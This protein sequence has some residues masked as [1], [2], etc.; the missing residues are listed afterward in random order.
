MEMLNP[1]ERVLRAAAALRYAGVRAQADGA[2]PINPDFEVLLAWLRRSHCD[3]SERNDSQRDE[4]LLRM[5]Q[6]RAMAMAELLKTLECAPAMLR[7][8]KGVSGDA[9]PCMG[10]AIPCMGDAIPCVNGDTIPCMVEEGGG[11]I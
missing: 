4:V 9:I 11:V 5:G 7:R 6:G 3:Q 10:D 8:M 1:N 2:R